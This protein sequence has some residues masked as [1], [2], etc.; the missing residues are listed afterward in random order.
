[1]ISLSRPWSLT[2]VVRG[3]VRYKLD[4]VGEVEFRW[5]IEGALRVKDFKLSVERK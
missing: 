2:T 4:F 3:L 5:D 1:V